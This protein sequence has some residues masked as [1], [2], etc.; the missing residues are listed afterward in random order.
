MF[1]FKKPKLT[2]DAFCSET[3]KQAYQYT[4]IDY[5]H[6]FYPQWWKDLPKPEYNYKDMNVGNNMKNC[7]GFIDQYRK[8]FII[9]MWTDLAIKVEDREF[10]YAFADKLGEVIIHPQTQRGN[11]YNNHINVKINSPWFLKSKK[12]V[13]FNFL[14]TFWNNTEPQ[15]YTV[16]PGMVEYYYQSS[17]NI[18]TL[19]EIKKNQFTIEMNTPMVHIIPLSESEVVLK[20]HLISDKEFNNMKL[21][22]SYPVFNK[23]YYG[24]KKEKDKQSKCPFGFGK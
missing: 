19:I 18:N 6:R 23:R 9:P 14:P 3:Y 2:V 17:T 21:E 22:N 15:E 11:F 16:L 1:F 4:P 12:G 5:A 13:Y 8:G 24:M 20:R 7:V 10:S